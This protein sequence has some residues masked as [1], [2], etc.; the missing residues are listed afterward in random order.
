MA[1]KFKKKQVFY[2]GHTRARANFSDLISSE[3]ATARFPW[4][5]IR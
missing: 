2:T 1:F 4:H 5:S 3:E